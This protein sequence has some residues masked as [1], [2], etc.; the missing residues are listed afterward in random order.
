LQAFRRRRL[1]S[2]EP[3]RKELLRGNDALAHWVRDEVPEA[4]FESVQSEDV[5]AAYAKVIEWVEENDQYSRAAKQRFVRSADPWLIGVA[6]VK[7]Y[8]L[9]TYEVSAPES[10]ALIKL[11][12]VAR[13]FNVSCIP[14]YAMLRQLQVVLR[15]EQ[16]SS[17]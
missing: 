7:G 17:R 2:I 12:D 8:T 1:A 3:I 13:N 14:P 5:Q 9:V 16:Q 4:F 15:Y 6:M 10:K 11:P